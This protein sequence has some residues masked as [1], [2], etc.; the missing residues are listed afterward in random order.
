MN[1]DQKLTAEDALA[2]LQNNKFL[3]SIK[4][5]TEYMAGFETAS[6]RQI[7]LVR[8][9]KEVAIFAEPGDWTVIVPGIGAVSSFV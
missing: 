8:N 7:A 2:Y 4:K 1:L 6:G 9:R 5:P 3:K